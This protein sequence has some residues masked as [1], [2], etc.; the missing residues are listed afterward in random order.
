[1]PSVLVDG[2]SYAAFGAN[3]TAK[4]RALGPILT[5]TGPRLV[6]HMT[7]LGTT[8]SRLN[9]FARNPPNGTALPAT[10]SN[11]TKEANA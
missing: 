9:P 6:A 1:M 7:R 2:K 10:A 5:R 4:G 8:T 11:H 3:A